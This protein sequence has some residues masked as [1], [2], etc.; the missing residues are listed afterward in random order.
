MLVDCCS[1]S[2]GMQNLE[3]SCSQVNLL[4]L[5]NLNHN[6]LTFSFSLSILVFSNSLLG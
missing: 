4:Y 2:I 5:V 6:E 1:Y 3:R